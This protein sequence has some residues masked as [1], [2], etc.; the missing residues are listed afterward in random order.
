MS[1]HLQLL[2]V[3]DSG[4]LWVRTGSLLVPGGSRSVLVQCGFPLVLAGSQWYAVGT[5]GTLWVLTGGVSHF[6]IATLECKA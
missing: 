1:A 6:T 5:I 4:S 2:T 3:C